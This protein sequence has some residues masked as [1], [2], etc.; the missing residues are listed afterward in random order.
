MFEDLLESGEEV[1][2]VLLFS[3]EWINDGV[4]RGWWVRC[5]VFGGVSM[6]GVLFALCFL[7]GVKELRGVSDGDGGVTAEV[8]DGVGVSGGILWQEM[9]V[10]AVEVGF[11]GVEVNATC[12]EGSVEVSK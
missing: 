11:E 10:V 12:L 6:E 3:Q 4:I 1:G 5:R 9:S 7:V 8:V 2:G